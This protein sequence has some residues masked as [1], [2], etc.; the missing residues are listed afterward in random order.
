VGIAYRCD[1]G[2]TMVGIAY[3]CNRG[4]LVGNTDVLDGRYSIGSRDGVG[5][6]H[7]VGNS[8]GCWYVIWLWDVLGDNGGDMFGLVHWL[9]DSNIISPFNDVQLRADL[10]D[11]GSVGDNGAAKSLDTKGL[12]VLW[13]NSSIGDGCGDIEIDAGVYSCNT[14]NCCTSVDGWVG[15][16]M[17]YT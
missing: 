12:D 7:W 15:K 14:C 17:S 1:G 13:T 16:G 8:I 9:G 6:S 2:N 10:G 11:L 4:N 3:C 5:D